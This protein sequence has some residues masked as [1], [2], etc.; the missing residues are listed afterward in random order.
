M[1]RCIPRVSWN[2]AGDTPECCVAVIA[3]YSVGMYIDAH[4]AKKA[5]HKYKGQ[6]IDKLLA[7]Q[8]AFDGEQQWE[9]SSRHCCLAQLLCAIVAWG[10]LLE[11][12]QHGRPVPILG[13]LYN[14]AWDRYG[15][16]NDL[17]EP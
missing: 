1:D 13:M 4:G 7:S 11:L 15:V 8:Q 9:H 17:P 14:S 12:A 10:Q 2:A 5:L 16:F 6:D 3:V